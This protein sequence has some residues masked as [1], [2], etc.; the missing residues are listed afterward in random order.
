MLYYV[1]FYYTKV[2]TRI[3][4]FTEPITQLF[5]KNI[6]YTISTIYN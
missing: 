5:L 6:I 1:I 4:E 2:K 3:I